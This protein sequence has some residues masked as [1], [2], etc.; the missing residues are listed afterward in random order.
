MDEPLS[1]RPSARARVGCRVNPLLVLGAATPSLEVQLH[2][3]T[4][5]QH[6][7]RLRI[8]PFSLSRWAPALLEPTYVY[9]QLSGVVDLR[10]SDEMVASYFD[11]VILWSRYG[12][13]FRRLTRNL[14]PRYFTFYLALETAKYI[15][16]RLATKYIGLRLAQEYE[17]QFRIAGLVL[18]LVSLSR[19]IGM[20]VAFLM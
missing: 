19:A 1:I 4:G 14:I 18:I 2:L 9:S 20:N 13:D 17:L 11:Q 10:D 7:L 12:E 15:G 8:P 16:L 5:N 3:S 6:A